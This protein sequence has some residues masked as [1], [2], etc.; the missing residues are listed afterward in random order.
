MFL[1]ARPQAG[2]RFDI[3]GKA[4]MNGPISTEDYKKF[5]VHFDVEDA[6]VFVASSPKV[7][8]SIDCNTLRYHEFNEFLETRVCGQPGSS[9]A[10]M[11]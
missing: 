9:Y 1:I 3:V 4:F 10:E 8:A 2:G 11:I 6:I 7:D 5:L